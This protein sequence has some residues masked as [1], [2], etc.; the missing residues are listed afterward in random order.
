MVQLNMATLLV[1]ALP[2]SVIVHAKTKP[3]GGFGEMLGRP[4]FDAILAIKFE[5]VQVYLESIDSL[6]SHAVQTGNGAKSSWPSCYHPKI[7]V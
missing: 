2:S 6:G 3:V 1:F 4:N 7:S 5:R